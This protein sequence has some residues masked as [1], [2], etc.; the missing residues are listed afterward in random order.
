[1]RVK[2]VSVYVREIEECVCDC[3]CM[4]VCVYV[5]MCVYVFMSMCVSECL[6]SDQ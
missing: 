2:C 4:C 1:M 3:E 6:G 5:C